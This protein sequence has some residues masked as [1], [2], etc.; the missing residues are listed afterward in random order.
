MKFPEK[1]RDRQLG[2]QWATAHGDPYGVFVLHMNGLSLRIIASCGD[3]EIPW[4]HVSVSTAKRCPTWDEMDAVKRLFWDDDEAV[5]QLHPPRA[6]WVN[7]VSTC[8]HL[9]RPLRG[10]IPLPPEIAVGFKELGTLTE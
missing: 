4:E 1:L 7:N 3:D 5:M 10:E 6:N 2:T 9:W 8:L